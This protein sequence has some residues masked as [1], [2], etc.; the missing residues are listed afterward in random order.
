L[1]HDMVEFAFLSE[2]INLF[3][4]FGGFVVFYGHIASFLLL[5]M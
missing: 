3:F 2:L 4:D 1:G 5:L